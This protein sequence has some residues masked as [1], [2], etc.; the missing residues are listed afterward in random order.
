MTEKR[1]TSLSFKKN[2]KKKTGELQAGEPRLFTWVDYGADPP[3]NYVRTHAR[4][5]GDP[6]QPG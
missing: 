2:G 4:Q 6:T 3:A 5:E 1:E